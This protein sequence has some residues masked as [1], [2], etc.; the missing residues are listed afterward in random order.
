MGPVEWTAPACCSHS[1]DSDGPATRARVDSLSSEGKV[2]SLPQLGNELSPA[3]T[4]RAQWVL[5]Q[6][7][8]AD[9]QQDLTEAVIHC[10]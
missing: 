9:V 6:A 2:T 4:V 10:I 5:L 3:D 1:E 8:E 7:R